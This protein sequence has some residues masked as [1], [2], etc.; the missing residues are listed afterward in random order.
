MALCVKAC[1]M[2]AA[3]TFNWSRACAAAFWLACWLPGQ[4]QEPPANPAGSG[5]DNFGKMVPE[6]FVNRGVR[7]PSFSA[8]KLRSLV[9]ADAVTRLDDER[10]FA[11]KVALT[12]YGA[13]Q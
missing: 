13:K 2:V 7:I 1:E 9:L 6:G 8:G 5:L 4:G 10:L 11:E 12:F 3:M